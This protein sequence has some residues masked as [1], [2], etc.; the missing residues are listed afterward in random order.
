MNGNLRLVDFAEIV[1]IIQPVDL[2]AGVNN[3]DYVNVKN[4]QRVTFIVSANNGTAANDLTVTLQQATDAAG[5]GAK[6]LNFTEIYEKEGTSLASVEQFTKQTQSAANTYT[7]GTNGENELLYVLDV[8][9]ETLDIDNDFDWVTVN[10][11]QVG[12]AKVGSVIAILH[13]PK[14]GEDPQK[15]A[16]A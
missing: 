7:S 4:Y 3:G 9:P 11:N 6:A 12:A 15:T 8:A 14:S 2:N 10:L 16:I 5:T 1:S 13:G